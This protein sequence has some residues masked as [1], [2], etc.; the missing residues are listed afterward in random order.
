VPDTCDQDGSR[1]YQR[2][3]DV[4][5]AMRRRLVIFFNQTIQLLDYYS[6]QHKLR[7]VDGNQ[8]I[9]QVQ[10]MLLN[11]INDHLRRETKA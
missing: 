2:P 3:D 6:K 7:E 10:T 11:E 5:E 1:L 8:G 9:D 4:G